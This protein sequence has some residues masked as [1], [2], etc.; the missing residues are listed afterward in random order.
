[1]ELA[2]AGLPAAVREAQLTHY[3]VDENHSNAYAAWKRMGSPL[4]PNARQYGQLEEASRLATLGPSEA[5]RIANGA[6]TVKFNLPRQGVSLLVVEW[7]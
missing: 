4:A 6:A 5:L 7:N 1:V 2:L 3:R